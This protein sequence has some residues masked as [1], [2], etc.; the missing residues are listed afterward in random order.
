MSRT[1]KST[2]RVCKVLSILK[3]AP[4]PMSVQKINDELLDHHGI[5]VCYSTTWHDMNHLVAS[6]VADKH[7]PHALSRDWVFAL[8]EKWRINEYKERT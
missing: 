6:G 4:Q 2:I 5:D 3:S 7:R 8:A 1:G